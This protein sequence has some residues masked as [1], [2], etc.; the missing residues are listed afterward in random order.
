MRTPYPYLR[1]PSCV[2]ARHLPV[3]AFIIPARAFC[4]YVFAMLVFLVYFRQDLANLADVWVLGQDMSDPDSLT[5]PILIALKYAHALLLAGY[6]C[7]E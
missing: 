4:V 7:I 5:A 1:V 6:E 3:R 2:H